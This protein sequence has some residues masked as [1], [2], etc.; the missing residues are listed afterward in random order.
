MQDDIPLDRFW[1]RLVWPI[2]WPLLLAQLALVVLCL[3]VGLL[4]WGTMPAHA[5]WGTTFWLPVAL[6]LG[7]CLNVAVFLTLLRQ[8]LRGVQRDVD[9]A[10]AG[11]EDYLARHDR[12]QRRDLPLSQRLMGVASAC[13]ALMEGWRH[14]LDQ[15]HAAERRLAQDLEAS[16][17][18]VERL[19][20]GRVRAREES[21]L[22]SGYLGHLRQS[23]GPLMTSLTEV[24][25]SD[26][27]RP[28]SGEHDRGALLALR[29]RLADAMLLLENLDEPAEAPALP[30][31]AASGRVL[32]VD[33]GPVNLTLARQVLER[34]GLEVA[35]A[36]SGEE[37][38]ARLEEAAF[39]LVLMDIFMPGMDGVEASRR[40]REREGGLAARRRS[41]LVA[42]TAN[43]SDEDRHR[44]REAGM[45]DFLAK[46]YRPQALVDMVR[47]WLVLP[48]PDHT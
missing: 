41:V 43:A 37:A 21:R 15:R 16:R 1:S 2:L 13:E 12:P 24:L 18:R 8:R 34:Q 42:L 19:E 17:D 9:E 36:T 47:Q 46:P 44:F 5:S 23:L 20:A 45:D 38:L 29:E 32:I 27:L 7:S 28:D 40:W 35:T 11:V 3:L 33:D 22:K 10:L 39:D 30:G 31:A 14:D 48:E 25:E 4:L 6:L 26:S